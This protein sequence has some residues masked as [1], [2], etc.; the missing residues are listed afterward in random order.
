MVIH[1]INFLFLSKKHIIFNTS[2]AHSIVVI[3]RIRIAETRVRFSLS[4]QKLRWAD[5]GR[6]S[7]PFG[8]TGGT[9]VRLALFAEYCAVESSLGSRPP[10]GFEHGHAGTGAC[11]LARVS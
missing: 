4:P 9:F 2:R 7:I 11:R 10:I 5:G 8:S 3:R 1:F 6:G